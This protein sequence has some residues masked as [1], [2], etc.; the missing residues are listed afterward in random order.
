M[1]DK[2]KEITEFGDV[3]ETVSISVGHLELG[4][5]EEK[6]LTFTHRAFVVLA[7]ALTSVFGHFGSSNEES[8]ARHLKKLSKPQVRLAGELKGA[9]PKHSE[10]HCLIDS[11]FT[12][13]RLCFLFLSS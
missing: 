4:L 3:Q 7:D 9:A 12:R 13:P 6:Q 11:L 2:S 5:N 8:P 10:P 1:R